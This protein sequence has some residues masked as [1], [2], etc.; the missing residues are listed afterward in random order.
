MAPR[1][2]RKRAAMGG[3]YGAAGGGANC[4][5]RPAAGGH[6]RPVLPWPTVVPARA[7]RFPLSTGS[8]GSCL[9]ATF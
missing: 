2:A 5:T 7:I 3:C 1:G 6:T 8:R 4:G 9:S